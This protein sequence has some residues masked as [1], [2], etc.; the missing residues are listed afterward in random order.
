MIDEVLN[1]VSRKNRIFGLHRDQIALGMF[2]SPDQW[3]RIRFIKVRNPDLKN[4]LG[5]EA[6][7]NDAAF[8]EFFDPHTD[9]Y[10]LS[11][12]IDA[13]TRKKPAAQNKYDKAV[14]TLDEHLNIA[15][16]MFTG[17]LLRLFPKQNDANNT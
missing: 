5:I 15:Y 3:Q 14:I 8:S 12:Y 4:I 7:R 9:G 16:M 13:A 17:Q 6:D 11:S 1:K 2:I 10:I